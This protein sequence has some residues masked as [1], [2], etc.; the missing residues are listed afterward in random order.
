MVGAGWLNPPYGEQTGLWLE[1]MAAHRDGIGLVFARTETRMFFDFVWPKA[2][3]VVFLKGRIAFC[4]G[5]DGGSGG[6]GGCPLGS[7]QLRPGGFTPE[8]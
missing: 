2:N 8:L 3:A 1:K 7:P 6:G 4:S 5:P